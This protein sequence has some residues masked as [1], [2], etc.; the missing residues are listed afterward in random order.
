[1]DAFNNS[2]K[3][4]ALGLFHVRIRLLMRHREKRL[5][6]NARVFTREAD[7]EEAR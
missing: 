7:V 5:P 3:K 4:T 2:N 6:G 1:M